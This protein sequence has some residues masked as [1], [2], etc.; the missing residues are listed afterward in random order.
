MFDAVTSE[1]AAAYGQI[2]EWSQFTLPADRFETQQMAPFMPQAATQ[3]G[4]PWWQ[5]L[6]QYGAVRA[7]DNRFGPTQVQG[8]T[9]P[10]TFAGQNGR[11]YGNAPTNPQGQTVQQ[12]AAP[13]RAAAPDQSMVMLMVA[14]L[15]AFLLVS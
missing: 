8:N 2:P 10:G 14:G 3:A 5:S 12:P 13:A 15:V 11:T 1:E 7:I 4:V 9:N 6:V